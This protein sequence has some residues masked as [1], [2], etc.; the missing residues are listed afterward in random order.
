M[1]DRRGTLALRA[2][3]GGRVRDA[4]GIIRAVEIDFA[5]SPLAWLRSRRGRGGADL[6]GD[7]EY[8]AGERLRADY[9]LAGLIR[10]TTMNWDALGGPVERERGGR[11]PDISD[12]AMAARSRVEAALSA[13]GPD[14]AGVLVDVCCLL[15]TLGDVERARHYPARSGKVVLRLA[16]SALARHYGL[17]EEGRGPQS[18]PVRRWGTPDSRPKA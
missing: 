2:R 1:T 17:S 18:A 14:L 12:A 9:T 7:A 8:L 6:I 13:V 11:A 5:E 15:R 10:R 3:T 4:D 16:L